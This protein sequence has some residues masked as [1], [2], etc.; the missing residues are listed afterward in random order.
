MLVIGIAAG[1]TMKVYLF[2]TEAERDN[3]MPLVRPEGYLGNTIYKGHV[4]QFE[5]YS[6]VVWDTPNFPK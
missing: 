1:A 5:G 3:F 4:E 6:R 2:N